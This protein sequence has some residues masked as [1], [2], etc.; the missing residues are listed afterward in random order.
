[1]KEIIFLNGKFIVP[2][3]ALVSALSYGFLYGWGVFETMRASNGRIVYLNEHLHRLQSSCRNIGLK[4]PYSF[5][6]A[7]TIINKAV[8]K[9]E[10][11]DNYVKLACWKSGTNTD[12]M[13]IA[14][15]YIPLAEDIYKKGF[16][17]LSSN[18]TQNENS[19]LTRVKSTNRLLQELAYQQAKEK[20]FDEAILLNCRGHICEA[21][22]S[23]IFFVK[24]EK[25]FT[26]SLKCGC[27]PGITRKV[28]F[29]LAKKEKIT[30]KE[31]N[32]TLKE[33]QQA[34]E[35]FLT[36]SLMGIMPVSSVNKKDIRLNH[37]NGLARYFIKK[38]KLL[39][40]NGN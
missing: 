40:N 29:D 1:M 21:T 16:S 7:K 3:K 11:S 9:N 14:R 30:L 5:S 6:K 39:I 32:F 2:Q 34:D 27:L 35:V 4:L 20:G 19:F 33:L 25:L 17:I 28:V 22:R 18:F 36:N 13:L 38:Y 31:G 15:E 24:N 10:F 12:F 8:G 37:S 23:N 26:P